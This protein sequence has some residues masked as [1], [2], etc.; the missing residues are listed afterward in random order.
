ML[1]ASVRSGLVET[2][3][4][5]AVAVCRPDGSLIAAAG[6]ID[7][8]FFI[9]SASKPFQ[10]YVS[11]RNGADLAPLQMALASSSHR[12][13]PVQVA[14]VEQML[15]SVGLSEDDLGCPP[16]W[17]SNREAARRLVAA[18]ERNPRRLWHNCSGK[19]S[20]FLRACVAS[21]WSTVDYLNPD[22]PV[23]VQVTALVEELGGFEPGPVGV[24]GCGAPVHRTTVRAMARM[25]AVLATD[26]RFGQVYTAMHRY[27]ALVAGNGESDS[28][29]ATYL[30]AVAKG[31]AQGCMGVGLRAGMGL[32][33][34]SW[35][36]NPIVPGVG[37]VAALDQLGM[38]TPTARTGL[39]RVARPV[40]LGRGAPVGEFEP[41]LELEMM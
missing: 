28:Q 11:Q 14:V 20:G 22:H 33:V 23:Q 24:D 35:D 36:G 34:K 39:A 25:F 21:G 5:G 30:D 4:D 27:P 8:P 18:G 38:L 13:H 16:D 17:P 37:A 10:A 29:I 41:R 7:R 31:G 19:H 40:V 1:A 6:D 15:G 12:G 26:D 2:Y 3:H 9:R 32:A